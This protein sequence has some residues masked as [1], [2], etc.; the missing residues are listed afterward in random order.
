MPKTRS[1][2]TI[3]SRGGSNRSTNGPGGGFGGGGG[4]GVGEMAGRT[5][6]R[7]ESVRSV[8]VVVPSRTREQDETVTVT[9]DPA[10]PGMALAQSRSGNTYTVN[11][12][13]ETCTCPNNTLVGNRCRHIEAAAIAQEQIGR[14]VAQG[15]EVASG[16]NA[17]RT[18]P[19]HVNNEQEVERENAERVFR[20]DEH[21]YL[22]NMETFEADL[23][24]LRNEP[25]PYE[26]ENALNG[27]NITFGVEL[28][29]Q[30]GNS[31]AIARELHQ[32]GI[33]G[34]PRMEEYHSQGIPGKWKL[35]R[36][37]SVTDR[38]TRRGGE[39]VSPILKDTP[40]TWKNIEKICEVVKRHGGQVTVKTGG[41]V[42]VS[43][44]PLDGK[45]HRWKRVM[46]AFAGNEEVIMRAAGG[47][48]GV[49]RDPYFAERTSSSLL[50]WSRR[51]LPAT[52][53]LSDFRSALDR[54]GA[55][56]EKY[57]SLNFR[58]FTD[59]GRPTLEVR[60]FNGSFTPAVIQANVKIAA[61]LIHTAER[62]RKQGAAEG[63]TTE[64]FS[65][66][67]RLIDD[68]SNER[69][70]KGMAKFLDTFFT[71]KSDKDHVLGLLAKN[72]FA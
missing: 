60:S 37:G 54:M 57:Q 23:N 31:D 38:Y 36:D 35:E 44:D 66:R 65:R 55:G 5:E 26:Y 17:S 34:T 9:F 28:E 62:S 64:A 49:M 63:L 32:L 20:D 13:D 12:E 3:A 52:E 42:H 69:S 56:D 10:M 4:L 43:L 68:T 48:V 8:D 41:H 50:S 21:F 53:N 71:R 24:R 15:S 19:D 72:R 25:L 11:T 47:E 22:D 16:V 14:G 46:K 45:R 33:V 6:N 18:L 51:D 7:L 30:H 1:S 39:L 61:G 27:S 67:G 70:S 59:L 58:G 29:F 40:E 2:G